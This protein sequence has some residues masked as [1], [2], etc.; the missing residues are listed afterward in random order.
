MAIFRDLLELC[1][2]I[3]LDDL[4]VYSKT[5]EEH[6]SHVLLV[7]SQLRE[8]GLYAKLEKCSFDC[9]QVEFLGYVISSEDISMDLAKVETVLEW[10]T[11]R[12][13]RDVQCFLG[14]ANCYRKFIHDYSQLILPLTQLTTKGK[15]FVWPKEANMT[16]VDLKK[17]F[18]LAPILTHVD[19]QKPFIIEAD[20]VD[21]SLGSILS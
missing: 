14:F 1:L 4:L 19:L 7:L 12:S 5:Q 9:N 16:F 2:I 13:L 18:T 11:P 6:D 15:S 21:F 8:H 3:Y 10:Q 17:A 20:V